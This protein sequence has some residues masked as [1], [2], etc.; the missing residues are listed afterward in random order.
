MSAKIDTVI[1]NGKVIPRTSVQTRLR[2]KYEKIVKER[3]KKKKS[4]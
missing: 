2:D 3:M 4:T 1:I